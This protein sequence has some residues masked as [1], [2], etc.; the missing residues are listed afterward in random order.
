M[1]TIIFTSG[2]TS[3]KVRRVDGEV[4][5]LLLE[6]QQK[7]IKCDRKYYYAMSEYLF[8]SVYL[9]I[10]QGEGDTRLTDM[11]KNIAFLAKH[12]PGAAK[13]AERHFH[14]TIEVACEIGA[15]GIEGQT[16]LNLGRLQKAKGKSEQ[17]RECISEAITIIEETEAEVFLR[18]SKEEIESLK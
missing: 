5:G 6:T 16:Y 8:G 11:I 2:K 17:A 9:Q 12:V 7:F 10:V 13:K 3:L 4:V 1:D 14:K 15:K 18:Q